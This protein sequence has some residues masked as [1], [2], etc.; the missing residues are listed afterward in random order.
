ML[1]SSGFQSNIN[2]NC[3]ASVLHRPGKVYL[4]PHAHLLDQVRLA[5][6]SEFWDPISGILAALFFCCRQMFHC[7]SCAKENDCK[8]NH[9]RR[10]ELESDV[11]VTELVNTFLLPEVQK[12]ISR[13]RGKR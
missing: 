4:T 7:L 1:Q 3:F 8:I 10:T 6:I 5:Y 9:F 12:E 2:Q 13:Q 11:I